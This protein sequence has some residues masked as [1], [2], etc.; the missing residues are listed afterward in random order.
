MA[1]Q[2][3][4]RAFC[5]WMVDLAQ[6][7]RVD[8]VVIAGDVYD[9]AIAPVES[10]ELFRRTLT[11]L[12]GRGIVVAVISGNHDSADRVAPYD[13][14]LDLSGV[15]IRGGYERIGEVITH[16]F[17]DGPLHLVP[18]PFLEPLAAPDDFGTETGAEGD[19]RGDA[20]IERRHRRTHASVLEEAIRRAQ[21]RLPAGRS[22]AMAHAFVRGGVESE[23]ERHL[24]VGGSAEVDAGLFDAF[25]Y[26]ALGHLHSP[27]HIV[28]P[29]LRYSGSPLAYS[30]SED[31]EKSVTLVDMDG[32][33]ACTLTTVPVPV[34]RRVRTLRGTIEELLRPEAYPDAR[35]RWVRAIVTDR[36]TVLD[37]KVRLE[38]VYPHVVEVRLEPAAAGSADE[39]EGPP[40]PN[41][42]PKSPLEA[43]QSFWEAVEG[44]EPD[45]LIVE[46]LSRAVQEASQEPR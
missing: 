17:G 11:E 3:D 44:A 16:T 1:L 31:H 6:R 37:A 7:E 24:V 23:S 41:P 18:L 40:G 5:E 46:L 22:L 27:H 21:T 19:A 34:G 4:Q 13:D 35:E 33:G 32:S 29:T 39:G 45:S 42:P 30:F 8:L 36:E 43:T 14:L 25:S 26:V 12:R 28:R 2:S 15:Y 38:R 20:L 9:R 10:I